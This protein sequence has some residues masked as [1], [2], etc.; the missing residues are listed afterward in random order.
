MPGVKLVA[1][2]AKSTAEF[3]KELDG[4][5]EASI[6]LM[7]QADEAVQ[8]AATE[9]QAR[10]AAA[11]RADKALARYIDPKSGTSNPPRL[12]RY[13]L[14]DDPD[15]RALEKEIGLISR[16]RRLFQ[17]VDEIVA[18]EK[19][20]P[21]SADGA[22]GGPDPDVPDRIVIYIDDLDRCT[23]TQVYAVLQAV[24]LLL[25]FRL[26]VVVVGVDVDWVEH[27]LSKEFPSASPAHNQHQNS[28]AIRYL[29]KI[30]QLPFWLQ[31][32]STHGSDGGSYVGLSAE[33]CGP[34][35]RKITGLFRAKT[36]LMRA[37][38][39]PERR[40]KQFKDNR[41]SYPARQVCPKLGSNSLR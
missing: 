24:H 6:K 4:A 32:L 7:A 11:E 17:A 25:A 34:D 27:A 31:R 36:T 12:L 10:R 35:R 23:P 29:E 15:T 21:A 5:A 19:S 16:V 9:A 14:E 8:R 13:M 38:K 22:G 3:A 20:K 1:N 39:V 37:P 26:F 28:L 41:T 2:L 40:M 30:F 33:S 18:E